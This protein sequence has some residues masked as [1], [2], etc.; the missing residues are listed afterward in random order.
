MKHISMFT[1]PG[2]GIHG[3]LDKRNYYRPA[4]NR[5]TVAVGSVKLVSPPQTLLIWS[6]TRLSFWN[7]FLK[8][9]TCIHVDHAPK[10]CRAQDSVS[11]ERGW[12]LDRAAE[13][14]IAV[15]DD[16]FSR[17]FF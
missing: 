13:E 2:V 10:A 15:V 3:E 6:I 16:C 8:L 17:V 4:G 5:H 11:Q 1:R 9:Y 7:I 14:Y 12:V